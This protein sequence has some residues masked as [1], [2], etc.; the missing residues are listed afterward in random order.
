MHPVAALRN[1]AALA[2]TS[3]ADVQTV[4]ADLYDKQSLIAAAQDMDAIA[5]HLPFV[6][7]LKKAA[8]LGRN[9]AAAVKDSSV[10]KIVFNTSCYVADEDNGNPAHDGRRAIEQAII[11]SGVEYAI[12]ETKVFMDN[13]IRSWNKPS[14]V[15]SSIFAY[16]AKPDLKISW[17]CLDDVAA[18]MVEALQNDDLSSGR[19]AI[20][21]PQALIGDEVAEI[22]SEVADKPVTF[23]SMSPDEFASAMSLLVTGSAT[24]EPKSIYSGMASFY[25]FYNEQ[26]ISPL[27][28]DIDEMAKFFKTRPT[29]LAEW[30]AKQDW[31][32]PVDPALKIRMAGMQTAT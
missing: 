11:D 16:P 20:G 4:S 3:F 27:I 31:T 22:L 10:R 8:Q 12:F 17:I 32:D 23:K 7:D 30:A 19:Y 6:F 9:V 1:P 21:G 13:M 18:F 15:N 24:V 25:S 29:P 14:I 5:M 2:N 26:P 28:A